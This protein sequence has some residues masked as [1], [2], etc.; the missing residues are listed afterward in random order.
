MSKTKEKIIENALVLF[1]KDGIDA[2]TVRHIA[3]KMG[4]SHGNLCYH[5]PNRDEIIKVLYY[6]MQEEVDG[7]Y[8]ALDLSSKEVL[9]GITI[10]EKTFDIVYNYRFIVS[11]ASEVF[12]RIPEIKKH[13]ASNVENRKNSLKELI[14]TLSKEKLLRKNVSEERLDYL[15][16]Q[17]SLIA[18]FWV[19]YAEIAFKGTKAEMKKYFIGLIVNAIFPYLSLKGKVQIAKYQK[20]KKKNSKK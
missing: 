13:F 2:V 9:G 12:A 15:Y 1:N 11:N 6:K 17:I 3:A 8:N 7:L 5:Y 14:Q 20:R 10:L 16:T 19:P 18:D 4:I